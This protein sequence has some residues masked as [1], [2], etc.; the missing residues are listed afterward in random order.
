[1]SFVRRE[2]DACEEWHEMKMKI[3]EATSFDGG[4]GPHG[5]SHVWFLYDF[6]KIEGPT[7]ITDL[8]ISRGF[9]RVS[10]AYH[11]LGCRR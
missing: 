4:W 9:V 7:S 8:D 11:T 5:P 1:M 2:E 6:F 3:V 10:Y